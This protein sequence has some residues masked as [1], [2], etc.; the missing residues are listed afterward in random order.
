MREQVLDIKELYLDFCA[1]E[2]IIA[3]ATRIAKSARDNRKYEKKFEDAHKGLAVQYAVAEYLKSKSYVVEL[4]HDRRN[5]WYDIIVNGLYVDVK[6][7]F[8]GKYWNQSA[9]EYERIKEIGAQVLYFC[10]DYD[11][12]TDQFIHCGECWSSQL[13]SS[14]YYGGQYATKDQLKNIL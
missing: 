12:K 1:K 7:R 9:A 10:V 6:C 14:M 5:W 13:L 4:N 3:E 8:E 11:S 2:S